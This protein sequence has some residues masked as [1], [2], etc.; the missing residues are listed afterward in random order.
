MFCQISTKRIAVQVAFAVL[1]CCFQPNLTCAEDSQSEWLKTLKSI[2]RSDNPAEARDAWRQLSD[3]PADTLP[4]ILNAFDSAGP[5]GANWLRAAVDTIA[6]R[7][8]ANSKTLPSAELERFVLGIEHNPRARRL[9]YEWLVKVDESASA[10]LLPG[11]LNDPSVD[12]RR[13]AVE[14]HIEAA[15]KLEESGSKDKAV[16]AF[17]TAL[18]GARDEDQVKE[19]ATKLKELGQS[20]D[21]PR[22]F[23]FLTTWHLIGPFDNTDLKGFET[24]FAPE[25][26]INLYE[27]Y[28]GKNGAV[29]WEPVQGDDDFGMIDLNE[30]LGQ[31]K[32]VTGYAWTIYESDSERDVEL[33]LGCKN[34]WKVWLNGELLFAREEYHRGMKMD[35][36]R[37]K[38]KMKQGKNQILIKLCQNEMVEN[39]TVEWQFQ[40]RVCDAS[41]TAI[42]AANRK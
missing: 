25:K 24:E 15:E 32:E 31:L 21:L 2:D 18:N 6:E 30:P 41:G 42:L 35:Q 34:A 5:L 13:D 26:Q 36:Y 1:C 29:A 10:R 7:S 19:L 28:E 40:L 37:M 14:L 27:E 9:A 23:G 39:W 12:L 20:V 11:M 33:R 38:A 16:R 4:A 17:Q 22:H 8:L 3:Q